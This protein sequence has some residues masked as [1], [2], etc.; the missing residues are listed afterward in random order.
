VPFSRSEK[1]RDF[2]ILV[3]VFGEKSVEH[4]LTSVEADVRLVD[5]DNGELRP[6][7]KVLLS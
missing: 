4:G 3:V 1:L 6:N 5:D 7:I 2:C